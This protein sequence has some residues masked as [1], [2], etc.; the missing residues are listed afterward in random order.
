MTV[1]G[2]DL[3]QG[4]F[5]IEYNP[6]I[7]KDYKKTTWNRPQE[8]SG[9]VISRSGDHVVLKF[10]LD[11]QTKTLKITAHNNGSSYCHID[12][13]LIT[14]KY[15]YHSDFFSSRFVSGASD[16]KGTRELDAD[17]VSFGPYMTLV[18]GTYIMEIEG[19][20]LEGTEFGVTYKQ[21]GERKPVEGKAVTYT[22]NRIE[23]EFT[24]TETLN[25]CEF[26]V[27]NK[28]GKSCVLNYIRVKFKE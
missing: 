9:T 17:G 7:V 6:V 18:P 3:D 4:D 26:K 11:E 2:S 28:S 20:G 13:L 16:N 12:S 24:V 8:I 15:V 19:T 10:K 23:Y 5:G 14:K 1:Q 21:G 22:D 25:D 27:T